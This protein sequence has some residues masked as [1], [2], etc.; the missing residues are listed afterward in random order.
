M[1]QLDNT[2]PAATFGDLAFGSV[3]RTDITLKDGSRAAILTLLTH[4]DMFDSAVMGINRGLTSGDVSEWWQNQ[5][6]ILVNGAMRPGASYAPTYAADYAAKIRGRVE[7]LQQELA[8][9]R[10]SAAEVENFYKEY[11]AKI[12]SKLI[13]A[14][15]KIGGLHYLLKQ[16]GV[17][18]PDHLK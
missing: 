1:N 7:L 6:Y 17:T 9:V 11:N 5:T 2:N 3:I 8:E 14:H 10:E 4:P 13:A 12:Y 15:T 16:A 18:I